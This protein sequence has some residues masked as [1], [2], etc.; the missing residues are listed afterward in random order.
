MDAKMTGTGFRRFSKTFASLCF[1]PKVASVLEG[2]R[3]P[4]FSLR[5]VP[6]KSVGGGGGEEERKVF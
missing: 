4:S 2:L 1:W 6:F 3:R 5:A